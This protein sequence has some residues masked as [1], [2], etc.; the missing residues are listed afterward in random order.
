LVKTGKFPIGPTGTSINSKVLASSMNIEFNQYYPKYSTDLIP[1]E[2]I[3]KKK[4]FIKSE[5]EFYEYYNKK[6]KKYLKENLNRFLKDIFIKIKFILFNVKKDGTLD[7]AK[8]EQQIL[9]SHIISKI[10]FNLSLIILFYNI[11]LNLFIKRV[12]FK[13]IFKDKLLKKDIYFFLFLILLIP[14]HILA[15]ATSKHLVP[16]TSVSIIYLYSYFFDRISYR[17]H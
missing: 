16:I 3:L 5:W 10:L 17:N 2:N 1:V 14:P 13:N 15:W 12:N 9:I 4:N 11:F 7:I 6:N 8:N